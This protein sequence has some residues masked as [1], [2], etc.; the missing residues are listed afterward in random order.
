MYDVARALVDRQTP[1]LA[2]LQ[3]AGSLPA[4]AADLERRLRHPAR[5][6]FRV[7]R[8]LVDDLAILHVYFA[9]SRLSAA[10]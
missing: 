4:L 8:A 3:H 9:A 6:H 5:L 7:M 2:D 1:A 10:P